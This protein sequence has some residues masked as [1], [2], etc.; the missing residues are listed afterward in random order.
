MTK[1]YAAVTAAYGALA[2]A[3]ARVQG[4]VRDRDLPVLAA[5]TFAVSKIVAKEK[6]GSWMRG[7]PGTTLGELTNCS[8]CVGV[9]AGLALVTAHRARPDLVR[10]VATALA[11]SAANDYL[12]SAFVGLCHWSNRQRWQDPFHDDNI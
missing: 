8:R 5:A 10:P 4:D 11:L 1:R 12:Q 9:W 2:L 6:I 3:S 7:D